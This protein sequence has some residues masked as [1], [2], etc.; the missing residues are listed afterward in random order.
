MTRYQKKG[1]TLIELLVVVLIIGIL[2]A[3][4][5]PQ[6]EAAVKKTRLSGM[7]PVMKT[8]ADVIEVY[9]LANGAWPQYWT[10]LDAE[11]PAGCVPDGVADN[12]VQ[13]PH[14]ELDLYGGSERN[15]VG[16]LNDK[17]LGWALGLPGSDEPGRLDCLARAGDDTSARV[18]RSMGGR[19]NGTLS[20][21]RGTF[22]RYTL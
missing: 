18:C 13:C 1:F 2:S 11:M 12:Y 3:V 22:T 6:Y 19:E 14:Y 16:Y 17:T 9:R 5:L 8:M 15:I 7:L 20:F 21:S 10:Q 4:A